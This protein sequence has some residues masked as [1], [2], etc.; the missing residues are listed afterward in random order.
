MI[1]QCIRFIFSGEDA[2]SQENLLFTLYCHAKRKLY[3]SK[4]TRIYGTILLYLKT[5]LRKEKGI[6]MVCEQGEYWNR[7]FPFKVLSGAQLDPVCERTWGTLGE[8]C[9]Q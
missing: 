8:H 9:Q 7:S 5:N 4:N 3:V 2:S 1:L 6:Q